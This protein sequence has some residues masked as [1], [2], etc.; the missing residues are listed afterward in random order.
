LIK[1]V[2][3]TVIFSKSEKSQ[4]IIFL[5]SYRL[6]SHINPPGFHVRS[7]FIIVRLHHVQIVP[8]F[9]CAHYSMD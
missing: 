4:Y 3:Y 2:S 8:I 1:I 5:L 7:L 6:F 9:T